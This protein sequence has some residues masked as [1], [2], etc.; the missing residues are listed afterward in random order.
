MTLSFFFPSLYFHLRSCLL[1]FQLRKLNFYFEIYIYTYVSNFCVRINITMVNTKTNYNK[2]I[3]VQSDKFC[4][5][6]VE[7]I[8]LI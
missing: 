3:K 2:K 8:A 7:N 5:E 4:D 6:L 1:L